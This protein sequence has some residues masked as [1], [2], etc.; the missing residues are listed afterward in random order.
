MQEGWPRDYIG[1]NLWVRYLGSHC[2]DYQEDVIKWRHF[3]RYW[4]FVWGIHRSPVNSPHKGQ[5]RGA[6]TFYLICASIN[7]WVNNREG[8]DFR[9]HRVH[10][11]V[12]VMCKKD[13]RDYRERYLWARNLGSHY[14]HNLTVI[15]LFTTVFKSPQLICRWHLV[16]VY[17]IHTDD[18]YG[19][20]KFK[21]VTLIRK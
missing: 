21:C 4:P 12:I 6:L 17:R 16:K 10:Y 13:G 2:W 7:G 11:D 14:W 5:W 1:L 8:D 3:P 15:L 9:R 19:H 20:Q 18:I